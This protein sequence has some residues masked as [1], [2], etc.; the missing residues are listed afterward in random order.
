M[1][2]S[3]NTAMKLFDTY[4][5]RKLLTTHQPSRDGNSI[6]KFWTTNL[7]FTVQH[8]GSFDV[9]VKKG[10][11][12]SALVDLQSYIKSHSHKEVA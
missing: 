10:K 5:E 12:Q 4:K 9:T 1:L 7:A 6:A 8:N 3:H 2:I 11:S